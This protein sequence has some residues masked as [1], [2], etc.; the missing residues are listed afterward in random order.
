MAADP[1]PPRF[2]TRI[3]ARA[4][5]TIAATVSSPSDRPATPGGERDP[6]GIP[7]EWNAT[8]AEFACDRTVDELV[9]EQALRA[10]E[11]LAVAGGGRTLRYAELNSRANQL[12]RHLCELGVGPEVL[13]G[14]C[15]ERSPEM[16]VGLLGI[17]KAGG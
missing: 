6:L 11:G 7:I 16:V 8:D 15:M 10:P 14:V 4:T 13:V 5:W 9:A 12:A 3:M 17:L 1:T 2:R